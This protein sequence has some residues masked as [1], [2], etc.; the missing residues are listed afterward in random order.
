MAAA[1]GLLIGYVCGG[2]LA[3]LARLD[4]RWIGLV[5]VALVLQLLIFPMFGRSPIVAWGT[6]GLHIA[7]YGLLVLF[8]IRNRS[9]RPM[10]GLGVGAAANVTAI[11][12]NGGRMP[13]SVTALTRAGA[14]ETVDHLTQTGSVGNVLLMSESTRLNFLGDWLY[15]PA[16]IPGATAFSLGDLVLLAGIAWIIVWGMTS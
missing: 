4:F 14:A 11:L 1:L 16:G 9:I 12:A 7:S 10:W 6:V 2:R 15:L 13:A 3:H 8:L 5:P